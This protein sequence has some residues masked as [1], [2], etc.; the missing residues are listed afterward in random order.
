M[1]RNNLGSASTTVDEMPPASAPVSTRVRTLMISISVLALLG[2][3]YFLL[4]PP[5]TVLPKAEE[6]L[7]AQPESSKI[8]AKQDLKLNPADSEPR[9]TKLHGAATTTETPAKPRVEPMIA[10]RPGAV[11][12]KSA[13]PAVR[14]KQN[15]KNTNRNPLPGNRQKKS[16]DVKKAKGEPSE[17]RNPALDTWVE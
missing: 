10:P 13:E 1:Y 4:K 2:M 12:P 5:P 15:T 16:P 3:S 7:R 11:A 17:E 14:K 8:T 6:I 9:A